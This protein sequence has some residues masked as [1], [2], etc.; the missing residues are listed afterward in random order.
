MRMHEQDQKPNKAAN[1]EGIRS[2][3]VA[4]IVIAIFIAGAI[5]IGQRFYATEKEVLQQQCEL[6]AK[7]SAREYDRCLLTRS[8]IVTVA[9]YTVDTMMKSGRDNHAILEYLTSETN[10]IVATLDPSTTGIYG[11][12]N[13]EYLDGSGWVP[14][15]DYVASERPWYIQTLE[16]KRE[17]T[18][19]KPYL[20]DQTET[21][22]MTVTDLLSDNKSV[23][24][25]DVSLDPIQRIIEE[26]SSSTEGSQAFV[27]DA[28]GIVV[29]HSDRS[30]LGVNYLT[31]RDSLGHSIAERI[32]GEGQMQFDLTTEEGDF[33]VY[34]DK[35]EGGWYSI[36]LINTDIWYEPLQRTV[37]IVGVV[38][39]VLI[40]VL[41]AVF[42]RLN[43]KNRAL[44]RLHTRIDQ[45]KRRG[46][47]LQALSETDRMTGLYDRV[48]GKRKVDELLANDVEG[49]FLELDID[50]FKS[51]NDTYGHQVGDRVILE[52][53]DALHHTF[54]SNDITMRLG[55]DEFGAF[56]VGITKQ[57]MAEAII[58]RMF[59]RLENIDIAELGDRK[60]SASVGAVLFTGKEKASFDELYAAVDSAMYTSKKIS[61]NSLTF[62]KD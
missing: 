46:N 49:V 59:H 32:L 36:S 52:V 15:A 17:I 6:N 24:A 11:L 10:Y 12:I 39:A 53:A 14:D 19:V 30:Q 29:A 60:V 54:R 45:E 50:N 35:L 55:G 1:H 28:G 51:I 33:S 9:G 57:D 20:D 5:Y 8:N 27:M 58:H 62:C 13:G 34:V 16:S 61:G 18:F 23:I 40:A 48:S 4:F 21:V 41:T 37:V 44:L 42:L 31:T 43:A 26:V 2:L 56:A 7:D 3:A 38:L 22:M 25:M 47:E